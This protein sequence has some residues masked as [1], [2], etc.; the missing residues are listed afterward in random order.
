MADQPGKPQLAGACCE[1]II[2]LLAN[3][4][5]N[6]AYLFHLCPFYGNLQELFKEYGHLDCKRTRADSASVTRECYRLLSVILNGEIEKS[7]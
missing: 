1:A 4:P 7:F 6:I 5:D 3:R 2:A